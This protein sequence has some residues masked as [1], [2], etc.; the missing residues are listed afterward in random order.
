MATRT[1][2][3]FPCSTRVRRGR[4]GCL[5]YSGAAVFSRPAQPL[6]SAPVAS[7]RP[8]LN[9]AGTSHRAELLITEHTKI[10]IRS[11]VRPFPRPPLPD[12][13]RA[14]SAFTLGF[15]PRGHPRR[16]PGQ[17][18][19]VNTGPDHTLINRTSNRHDHSQRATSRR[20]AA[21][22]FTAL[23]RQNGGEGLPPPLE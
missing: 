17:E 20:T 15:A 5:L 2:S 12:G 16:T 4:G 11:P 22:S 18:R 3:G 6:W 14:A 23:L 21:P 7:Q 13:T 8:A 19:P 9:P 1:L 10:H